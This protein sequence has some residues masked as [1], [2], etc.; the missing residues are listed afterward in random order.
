MRQPIVAFVA[1]AIAFLAIDAVWLTLAASRLYKPLLGDALA[2]TFR[3][4]PA[5]AFY[6]I[7]VVG[8]VF[9]AVM[10]ALQSG[11]WLTALGF[12]ALFG[13]CAYATYDLTNQATLKDWPLAITLADLAWGTFLSGV[14]ASIGFLV[15][16][17]F[18]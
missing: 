15:A 4:G 8:L 17:R 16:S 13:F 7:Y 3:L 5:V 12:G 10:P 2:E 1:T 18:G 14:A 6:V 9:F 11:R